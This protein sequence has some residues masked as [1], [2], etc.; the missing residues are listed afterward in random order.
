MKFESFPKFEGKP[1]VPE[2]EEVQPEELPPET[3]EASPEAEPEAEVGKI[4]PE[5]QEK[6]EQFDSQLNESINAQI[7]SGAL[8]PEEA[9]VIREQAS[10]LKPEDKATLA[11]EL[12]KEKPFSVN[13]AQ[14]QAARELEKQVTQYETAVDSLVE[15]AAALGIGLSPETLKK[16]L[17]NLKNAE[18]GTK[19]GE[20]EWGKSFEGR[21]K[22]LEAQVGQMERMKQDGSL[23]SQNG[24]EAQK[25]FKKG[26]DQLAEKLAEYAV[27]FAVAI[28]KGLYKGMM[29][30][31][32]R[33]E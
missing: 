21:L 18:P 23:S 10:E 3:K 15:R 26:F 19:E 14:E 8:T 20:E 7:E 13:E 12:E 31:L 9:K 1:A 24:A 28:F 11:K 22:E 32:R 29:G 6:A 16:Y 17:E 30:A 2:G 25:E 27:R 4:S 33:K 5:I